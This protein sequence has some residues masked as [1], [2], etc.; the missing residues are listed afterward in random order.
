MSTK[1][2]LTITAN[3]MYRAEVFPL[4]LLLQFSNIW[5]INTLIED[6]KRSMLE[7]RLPIIMTGEFK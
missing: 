4:L 2:S 6:G 7:I 3:I 5:Q 1:V